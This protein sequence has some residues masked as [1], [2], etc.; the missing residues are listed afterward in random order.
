[1]IHRLLEY[2]RDF[3]FLYMVR[4]FVIDHFVFH[5]LI[6]F[7]TFTALS[8]VQGFLLKDEYTPTTYL[9]WPFEQNVST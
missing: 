6:M 9:I 8:R 7:L 5:F 3:E 4:T 1:M 2:C